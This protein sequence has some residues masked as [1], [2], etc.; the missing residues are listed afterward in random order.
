[1]DNLSIILILIGTGVFVFSLWGFLLIKNHLKKFKGNYRLSSIL[2]D[3]KYHELKARQDY[4]ISISA[5]LLALLSFIG[6]TSINNI[7][8]ELTEQFHNEKEILSSLKDTAQDNLEFLKL[9]GKNYEDSVRNALQLVSILKTQMVRLYNKDVIS[10]NIYIVDPL[11]L[12][13]FSFDKSN[14]NTDYRLVRFKDLVTISGQK[15]PTFNSP[16]SIICFSKN[17]SLLMVDNITSTSFNV[18]ADMIMGTNPRPEDGSDVR[19]SL[20]ISQKPKDDF[21]KTD[22]NKD[23]K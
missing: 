1:M 5:I 8:K 13:K 9:T 20:W 21:Y 18:K 11:E 15:L 6:Y 17:S 12:G 16:P 3:V 2:T 22:F 7:K 10:Q 4:L 23:F 14:P 19:F